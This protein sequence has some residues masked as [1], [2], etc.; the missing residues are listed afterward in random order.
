MS[1]G[2]PGP[3]KNPPVIPTDELEVPPAKYQRYEALQVDE[4][5]WHLRE[6]LRQHVVKH[7]RDFS[8][9]EIKQLRADCPKPAE[10]FLKPKAMDK[11]MWKLLPRAK[12][13]TKLR[14]WIAP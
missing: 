7:I 4:S 6:D 3:L 8:G 14:S 13:S 12:F 1:W 5:E 9:E 2:W 11:Q 10:S